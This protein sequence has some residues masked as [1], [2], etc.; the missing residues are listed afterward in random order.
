MTDQSEKETLPLLSIVLPVFNEEALLRTNLAEIR[1]H[2]IS[3][4]SEF[5]WEIV[6]VNDGS[7][8]ESWSIIE[9][10]ASK[11][12]NVLALRH[13]RNFGLGQALKYGFSNTHGDYVITLDI[14]LSY[15]VE[16]ITQL[17]RKIRDDRARLVLASP[18][19]S[20]G[21]IRN[22]PFL[23]RMLSILGNRFLKLFVHGHLSTL[24]SMVRAYDGPYIRA[25]N[26]R[27]VGMDVMPEVVYK[28]MIQRAS[29]DEVPA[30]LDWGPQLQFQ[31]RRS[32]MRLVR[33]VFSTVMSGFLFR[34][35]LFFIMPGLLLGF[36][37]AYVVFWMGYH[38]F[39]SYGILEAAGDLAVPSTALAHA[40][41][42]YPH[43]YIVGLLSIMLSIQLVGL[44]IVSL[45][46][47]RYYE[48]LFHLGSTVLRNTMQPV[49]D[50]S[51]TSSR[52]SA[53]RPDERG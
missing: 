42:A 46:N 28:A 39:E 30:R 47:K 17:A 29:I 4:E 38:F 7:E 34:P 16:H 48:E 40:Y 32:S 3:L 18:Y 1:D 2:L 25:L 41:N 20:G 23:R 43:T 10:F 52:E 14:D 27:A 26:L 19:T 6:I 11:H 24:T 22:V 49:R 21:T 50:R 37:A 35:F 44:G 33:H 36:F 8:D 51:H 53:T 45:Q 15:D 31:N 13:P 9:E 5:C 12:D